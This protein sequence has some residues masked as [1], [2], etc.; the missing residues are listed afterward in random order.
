MAFKRVLPSATKSLF[1]YRQNVFL[2]DGCGDEVRAPWA[3]RAL[4]GV[5]FGAARSAEM[6]ECGFG[7]KRKRVNAWGL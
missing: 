4:A 1:S 3:A 5:D 2:F 7:G 6:A